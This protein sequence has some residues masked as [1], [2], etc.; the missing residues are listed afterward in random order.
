ML[1]SAQSPELQDMRAVTE[2]LRSSKMVRR[3]T[4][5]RRWRTN[6]EMMSFRVHDLRLAVMQRHHVNTEGNL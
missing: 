5:S 3:V 6:A 4:T 2:A 1:A